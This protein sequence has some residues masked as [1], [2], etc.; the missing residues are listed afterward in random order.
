MVQPHSTTNIL[1]SYQQFKASI[2]AGKR[3][4]NYYELLIIYKD[5]IFDDV[6]HNKQYIVAKELGMT[7][8]KFSGIISILKAL[9]D[10]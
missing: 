3:L 8:S 10:N 7:P 4:P 6:F 1:T 5:D 2:E 9:H